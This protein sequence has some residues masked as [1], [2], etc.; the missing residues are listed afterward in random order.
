MNERTKSLTDAVFITL[1][2]EFI[3]NWGDRKNSSRRCL[4][5]R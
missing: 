1:E 3:A 5:L 4:Q 2:K